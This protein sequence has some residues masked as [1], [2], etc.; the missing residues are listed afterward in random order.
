MFLVSQYHIKESFLKKMSVFSRF[1]SFGTLKVSP[2]IIHGLFF[3]LFFY[4]G[5]FSRTFI[6]HGT[7]GEEGEHLFNS[8]L[9]LLPAS[10]TLRHYLGNYCRELNFAHSY[11]LESNREPVRR[12]PSFCTTT[13]QSFSKF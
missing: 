5:F 13:N 9:P 11:Q 3:Y 8:F 4:L 10:Q 6:I 2:W 12:S 7:A 1:S